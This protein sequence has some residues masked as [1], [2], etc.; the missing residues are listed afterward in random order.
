[1]AS[2]VSRITPVSD[3]AGASIRR[4]WAAIVRRTLPMARA[5]AT[6]LVLLLAIF[7]AVP[8]ILYGQFRAAD[9]DKQSLLLKAAQEQ[10]RLVAESIKPHLSEFTPKQLVTS[11]PS[12]R[13]LAA[14]KRIS[15][16]SIV[17]LKQRRQIGSTMSLQRQK[18]LLATWQV[19]KKNWFKQAFLIACQRHVSG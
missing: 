14:R 9:E 19:S 17:P 18:F 11:L 8:W 15:R 4:G 12:C 7:V 1:M 5:F 13:V 3:T 2:I 10:G 16:S 6:K